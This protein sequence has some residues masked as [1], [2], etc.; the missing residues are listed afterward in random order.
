MGS[1]GKWGGVI[2]S[3]GCISYNISVSVEGMRHD[4]LSDVFQELYLKV[5]KF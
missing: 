2:V 5:K 3:H 1:P 4:K